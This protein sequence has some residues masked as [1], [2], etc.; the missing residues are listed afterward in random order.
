[1]RSVLG[2]W[3][4][5]DAS[6]WK[7]CIHRQ[8]FTFPLHSSTQRRESPCLLPRGQTS[9]EKEALNDY[10]LS[11]RGQI[12]SAA[13]HIQPTETQTCAHTHTHTHTAWRAGL[14]CSPPIRMPAV[15]WVER[16]VRLEQRRGEEEKES[17]GVSWRDGGM[18]GSDTGWTTLGRFNLEGKTQTA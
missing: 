18:E 3:H 12:R 5:L 4:S 13:R 17:R 8:F 11:Y 1:M 16:G 14:T 6:V 9:Y 15:T 10:W 2:L 7:Y